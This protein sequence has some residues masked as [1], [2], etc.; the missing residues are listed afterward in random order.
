MPETREAFSK[1]QQLGHS[2]RPRRRLT[3]RID[4]LLRLN[5]EEIQVHCRQADERFGWEESI[6]P[7]PAKSVGRIIT[8]SFVCTEENRQAHLVNGRPGMQLGW[9]TEI[10]DC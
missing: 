2:H 10:E 1:R 7:L 9:L 3:S 8:K 5:M 6:G 4:R